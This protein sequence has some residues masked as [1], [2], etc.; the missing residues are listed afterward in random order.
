M[1]SKLRR[2]NINVKLTYN[3]RWHDVDFDI[4]CILS[5]KKAK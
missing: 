5:I 2:I 4:V 1:T 3:Q